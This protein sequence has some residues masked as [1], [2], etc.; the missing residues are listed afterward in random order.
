MRKSVL[1]K[2][3]IVFQYSFFGFNY[4]F[5]QPGE[6]TWMHGSMAAF[7]GG[8]YGVQ[9]IPSPTNEPPGVYEPCEW[10]DLNGNFWTFGGY[11]SANFYNDL[12]K[13]DPVSNQWTWVKGPGVIND[14]GNY[15]T[16][17]I[18]SPFN[19]PPYRAST[20]S[21]TDNLGNLWMFGGYSGYSDLWKFDVFSN[22]WTWIKG[23]NTP[24]NTGTYGTQGVPS[25]LNNPSGRWETAVTWTDA[26]GDLWLFGGTLGGILNDLWRY[27]IATDEWTWMQG[28]QSTG[29]P[30]VFGTKGIED[31][32]NTP[33]G[34]MCYSKWK[35]VSGNLWL[36]GGSISAASYNDLWRYNP[37]TNNWAWISGSSSPGAP[38]VYGTKCVTDSLNIP[39][40]RWENRTS[41]TD[42]DGNF[43]LFGGGDN[44][45]VSVV[46]ND[47]WKY[48]VA[49]NEWTWVSGDNVTN[50][51]GNWG[52][53][54]I[55]SPT[56]KPDGR[57]GSIG[58]TDNNGNL[59]MFGGYNSATGP[60]NDL[61]R[62][63]IDTT[64]AACI[65]VPVALFNAPNHICSGTCIDFN[66]LS[67]NATSYQWSFAG[68]I[69][70]VST[71]V[72]PTGICYNTPGT[73]DV[74][75]IAS[76][77][78]TSDTLFLANFIT[79]YPNPPPQGI[80][81]SGDTLFANQGAGSYQWYYNGVVIPGATD[82]FYV[83]P[84]VGDYNVVATDA[85]GCEVEAAIFDVVA[86]LTSA[87]SQ[88]EGVNLYPNPVTDKITIHNSQD[89]GET[90][91]QGVLRTI[92][93]SI[94]NVIG[95]KVFPVSLQ[96]A[97]RTLPTVLDVS[98]LN[99]G[100]YFL[101]VITNEKI[102]RGRFLK[103]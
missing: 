38:G 36:F 98:S 82:Y 35:D 87:L 74:E 94:Y 78:N 97:N 9:G 102:V 28:S 88:G 6:W 58:G 81:Q 43:W 17:G 103:K 13:Y 85:N 86:G 100:L 39:G 1:L 30:A 75:L 20:P 14:P 60:C 26:T 96:T 61:W 25:T 56:N 12:W 24:G 8:N 90:A 57:F 95:E 55:S 48:C 63:K 7:S 31:P 51:P 23:P 46:R 10:T 3:I 5:A 41:W 67:M 54:G 73:Y 65:S 18:S 33:G 92:E 93:I 52:T 32:L 91:P 101:E 64:C 42:V 62:F 47:L 40:A 16:L 59:Y 15:G 27:H 79:V 72:N 83:A 22:E 11:T 80:I 37:A 71:D 53:M 29:M 45:S 34:R 77:S 4:S 49:K 89:K 2:M 21:W 76:N 99:P 84:Q 50:A 66:N 19:N 70:A 69:P 68:A 44:T